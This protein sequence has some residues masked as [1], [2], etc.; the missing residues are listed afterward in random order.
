MI[1]NQF[2]CYRD[3]QEIPESANQLFSLTE[4]TS[5]FFSR[6]WYENLSTTAL[7]DDQSMMMACVVA[8]KQ[9]RAILPLMQQS[10]NACSSLSSIYTSLNTFLL[11]QDNRPAI[12][13]CMA[14]GLKKLPFELIR[15]Q[16]IAQCDENILALEQAMKDAGFESRRYFRFYNWTHRLQGQS[17]SDYMAARP[18]RVRSTVARKRRKLEREHGYEIRL[19]TR[20]SLEQAVA[21]YQHIYRAS[22]KATDAFSGFTAGLVSSFGAQGWLRL[23]I[24][25]VDGD[26]VAGQIWLIAHRKAN[27]FRL[28]FDESW[29]AYSPGS[30]LTHYLMQHAIDEDQVE[31]ID[32]L[33]GNEGYKQDWMSVR[34]E[35]WGWLLY[36]PPKPE[37]QREKLFKSLKK[38]T[39]WSQT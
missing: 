25:Y 11:S 1:E 39:F 26:A 18:G 12:L 34:N 35:R 27:I 17:F 36:K 5:L 20:D 24:L 7:S 29:R 32:F 4:K 33:T 30:I 10:G 23:A 38:L 19:Y 9:V 16:P 15:L 6:T 31:E 22:W 8:G 3:W 14:Q 21:D 13:S 37:T 28:A 2:V